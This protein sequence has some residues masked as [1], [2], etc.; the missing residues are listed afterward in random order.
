MPCTRTGRHQKRPNR[1]GNPSSAE[2]AAPSAMSR[3][4]WRTS[5]CHS[6]PTWSTERSRRPRRATPGNCPPRGVRTNRTASWLGARNHEV[7][8]P[9]AAL[10]ADQPLMPVGNGQLGAVALGHRDR[11]GLDLVP[12]IAVPD[13]QAN[14]SSRRGAQCHRRAAVPVHR[15]RLPRP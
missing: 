2:S 8:L 1:H 13:D 6:A 5:H 14:A 9:T 4:S 12:S 10:A 3:P 7:D 11:V 15:L